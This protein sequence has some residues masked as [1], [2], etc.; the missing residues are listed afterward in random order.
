MVKANTLDTTFVQCGN[1]CTLASYAVGACHFTGLR[2]YNCFWD[3]CRHFNISP[4]SDK[5][6][7]LKYNIDFH[8]R[9]KSCSGYQIIEH[10]HNCSQQSAFVQ[11]REKFAVEYIHKTIPRLQEIE[12]RLKDQ[13]VLVSI[14]FKIPSNGVHSCCVGFDSQN[15]YM[16]ETRGSAPKTGIVPISDIQYINK[17]LGSL[18]DSLL[19]SAR[20][21]AS[22]K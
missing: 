7:E 15:F 20:E 8:P 17:S 2:V 3:Y 11:G 9:Y 10:L 21:Q 16:I 18:Q 12:Q 19:M 14:A 4:S 1:S 13:E 5:D 22:K 6:A